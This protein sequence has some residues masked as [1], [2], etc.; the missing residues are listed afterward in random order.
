[1]LPQA[2]NS[3]APKTLPQKLDDG[4]TK[5]ICPMPAESTHGP[6]LIDELLDGKVWILLKKISRN[7]DVWNALTSAISVCRESLRHPFGSNVGQTP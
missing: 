1:M 5:N 3:L 4:R 2:P 7:D 6:E